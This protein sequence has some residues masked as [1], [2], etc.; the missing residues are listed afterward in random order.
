MQRAKLLMIAVYAAVLAAVGAG[1]YVLWPRERPVVVV[2]VPS[3]Q[4]PEET[5]KYVA[6]KEFEALDA[7]EKQKY[8]DEVVRNFE[9]QGVW[10]PPRTEL[11]PEERERLFRNAGPLFRKVMDARIDK[12]FAL[13]PEEKTAYLDNLIDRMQE[14]RAA[15][16]ERR[17]ERR[18]PAAR[19]TSDPAAASHS[20]TSQPPT[21]EG[22]NAP[23]GIQTQER[24][25]PGE[26]FSPQRI[27]E[28]IESTPPEDQAKR[29][30]FFKAFRKRMEE[31]GI[32]FPRG[33]GGF[34]GFGGFGGPSSPASVPPA[35]TTESGAGASD[36]GK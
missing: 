12:Y 6:S 26:R 13:P 19:S 9:S 4:T 5:I 8:F 14:M 18:E 34:R 20:E 15:G 23:G 30:E 17:R 24:R 11:T 10:R 35:R 21:A 1:A 33:P 27:K 32:Q 3:T 2:P 22:A 31:R 7:D 36:A 25:G 29:A 16:E 28:R